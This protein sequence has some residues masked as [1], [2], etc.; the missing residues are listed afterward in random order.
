MK[1]ISKNT[2]NVK[3]TTK[4]K[5]TAMQFVIKEEKELLDF[6]LENKVK[7]SRNSIKSVLSRGQITVDGKTVKQFNYPL[8]PGQT[9]KIA[10]NKTAQIQ[11]ELMGISILHEDED[12]IVIDK[13]AGVLSI[14]AGRQQEMTAHRQLKIYVQ[15]KNPANRIYVVHRLDR[16]TSGVMIFAKSEEIKQR[17]QDNWKTMVKERI[18]T[19]LVEGEVKDETGT[20]ESWLTESPKSY[21]VHSSPRDNGGQHAVTHYKKI[22]SNGVTSLLEVQLETGRKNQIRVH[23]SDIG[24][25][26]VGDRKYGSTTNYLKRLGLH[27]TTIAFHHPT[28]RK[29]VRFTSPVPKVFNTKIK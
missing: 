9:V 7:S 6:L 26:V 13:E 14:A 25:P 11:S 4:S 22:K 23:M 19:T 16:D 29:L 3:N 18:Y 24:H 28:S 12:I 27:A 2:K 21:K 10:D 17:L 5:Q 15:Q 1:K 20:I 8:K